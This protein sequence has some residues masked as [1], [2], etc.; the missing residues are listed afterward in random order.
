L[1]LALVAKA[2]WQA[3]PVPQVAAAEAAARQSLHYRTL[4][5]ALLNFL[6][7]AVLAVAVA[8]ATTTTARTPVLAW[9]PANTKT[10][11]SIMVS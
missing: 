4:S 1:A 6:L 5:R 7:R 2:V 3:A 9:T 11:A 10:L 8:R